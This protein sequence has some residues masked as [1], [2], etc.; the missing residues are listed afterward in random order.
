MTT[1]PVSNLTNLYGSNTNIN[2]NATG[3]GEGK[4]SFTQVMGK[5]TNGNGKTPY[6]NNTEKSVVTDRKSTDV[7]SNTGQKNIKNMQKTDNKDSISK[8]SNDT[9]SD[10][11]EKAEAMVNEIAEKLNVSEEDVKEVME[12]LGITN[13]DLLNPNILTQVVV[14]LTGEDQMSLVMDET[15]YGTLNTLLETADVIKGNLIEELGISEEQLPVLLD[16][17]SEKLGNNQ[18]IAAEG[19]QM[20]DATENAIAEDTATA[21]NNNVIDE[22]QKNQMKE[23]IPI[24]VVQDI[25]EKVPTQKGTEQVETTVS[26]ENTSETKEFIEK[27][28]ESNVTPREANGKNAEHGN[29]ENGQ[30]FLQGLTETAALLAEKANEAVS[31]TSFQNVLQTQDTESIMKQMMDYMKLHVGANVSEMEIQLQPANLGTVN[32]QVASKNGMITA[33]FTAQNETVKEALET[34]IVQLK[35][36]LDERGIKVEAIEVTVASHE[37]ER[38]LEQG[39]QEARD[40]EQAEAIKKTGRRRIILNAEGE[41]GDELEAEAMDEADRIQIELMQQHGNTISLQA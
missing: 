37:F 22:T 14:N 28:L 3:S 38:N 20:D 39:E 9:V 16:N 26:E 24:E 10:I 18:P 34:Q 30:T 25:R 27:P 32:L 29:Q 13:V 4:N 2:V 7:T 17:V 6:Q 1:A 15:L 35:E 40:S 21:G 5:V 12:T 8:I 23:D 41:E 19:L 11:D 36:N 31:D 33:Q